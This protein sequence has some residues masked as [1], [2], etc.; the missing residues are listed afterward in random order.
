MTSWIE[1]FLFKTVLWFIQTLAGFFMPQEPF[2]T[3]L[4]SI[5][6][7]LRRS[8]NTGATVTCKIQLERLLYE[9]EPVHE[10]MVE[11]PSTPKRA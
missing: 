6:S 2:K 5:C 4:M 3:E 1:I 9:P 7:E 10:P 11:A 8:I